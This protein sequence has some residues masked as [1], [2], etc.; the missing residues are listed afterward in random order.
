MAINAS[1]KGWAYCTPIIVVDGTFLQASYKGT[2]LTVATE[3]AGGKIFQ[4]AY[5]IVDLEN[6]SA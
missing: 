4:L 2:L 3:D 5:A 1:I 6:D